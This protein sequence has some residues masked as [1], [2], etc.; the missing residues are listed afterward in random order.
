MSGSRSYIPLREMNPESSANQIIWQMF[1][2]ANQAVY[3]AGVQSAEKNWMAATVTVSIFCND[4]VCVGH[5]GDSRLYLV[6]Q[7]KI[8][9]ITNDHSYVAMQQKLGLISEQANRH[10]QFGRHSL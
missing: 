6:Q 9:K 1:N 3:D 4:E 7:G 8:R 10:L 5:V 2:S